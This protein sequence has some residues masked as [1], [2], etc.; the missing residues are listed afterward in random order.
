MVEVPRIDPWSS[1]QYADYSKIVEAFGISQFSLDAFKLPDPPVLFRR[2]IVFAH[3]G[4]E[5]V[6][7]AIERRERFAVL[8]GLAPSGKMHMGHKMVVDQVMYYQQMGADIFI[9]VADI[10]AW[11]ARGVSLEEGR[12]IA[13]EEYVVN[14]I[15]LGLKPERCQI[16]FQSDRKEVK[17]LA[18]LLSRKINWSEMR[19]IYGFTDSNN[20]THIMSPLVQVGDI[21]HVQLPKHGGPCPTVVPVG[22]DQDPHIRLTRDVA[23]R[24]RLFS[25]QPSD[26]GAG[27]FLKGDRED[28]DDLLKRASDALSAIWDLEVNMPYRAL[29][30]K[31]NDL[32]D[33]DDVIVDL[34]ALHN[35]W[36][37]I[38]PSS[39]YNLLLTGLRGE[40]MSSSREESAIFLT[41][42]P[43]V[44]ASKVMSALT[45]GAVSAQEQRRIGGDPDTCT[46]FD[47]MRFHLV[48]DDREL[49]EIYRSCRSGERLCG[50][51]KR[52]TAELVR[53]FL[54]DMTD[55]RAQAVES[56]QDYVV[57]E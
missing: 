11:G 57:Q 34:E 16:Y 5:R 50:S 35:P 36:T 48:Q 22:I 19:A 49:A 28:A 7:R 37:F 38:Q 43:D 40:K 15:A 13:L 56:V 27:V 23:S 30:V 6:Y 55:R 45:G 14:Y 53:A 17:D 26:Y 32:I 2:G 8:T 20:M 47:L 31:T 42:D 33:V 44:G 4:F 46:V 51:C 1:E 24:F 52:F 10:E 21:L 39:T 18:F 9:G 41:D 25:V 54:K 3:R 12:R 29:Y